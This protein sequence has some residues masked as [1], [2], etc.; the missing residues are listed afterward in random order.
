M[1]IR[2]ENVFDDIKTYDD[3][4]F[5]TI[6]T[7][8]P[9][10]LG[11][12]WVI[13]KDGSFQIKGKPVD[14]M[15][16]WGGLDGPALDEMFKEMFRVLKYGGYLLMFALDRQIGPL[17]YYAVKNGFDVNQSLYWY[18]VC[19]DETT[20]L[21]TKRGW[22]NF[23]DIK[24]DDIVLTFNKETELSEWQSIKG[25]HIYDVEDQEMVRIKN[26]NVDQLVTPNHR[27]LRK[28]K[29]NPRYEYGDWEYTQAYNLLKTKNPLS[30]LPLSFENYE[31]INGDDL[32]YELLGWIFTD[33]YYGKNDNGIRISQCKDHGVEKLETLL[34]ILNLDYSKYERYRDIKIGDYEYKNYKENIYYIKTSSLTKQ[35]KTL[36]PD[37]KPTYDLLD[38]SFE[39]RKSLLKG[40]MNG[41]GTIDEYGN[42]TFKKNEFVNNFIQSLIQ[43]LGMRTK[44]TNGVVYFCE[45]QTT[46]LQKQIKTENYSGKVWSV[47]TD[48]SNYCIRRN[49]C[50]SFTGNSNFP[51]ATDAGKMIDKRLKKDRKVVGKKKGAGSIGTTF[52]SGQ[53]YT[54]DLNKGVFQPE[55]DDTEPASNLSKIF[56]GYKYSKAP[57]KQMVE[58]IMVFSKPTKNKSV[59]DDIME[60]SEGVDL[61]NYCPKVGKKERNA[62]LDTEPDTKFT[63][64]DEGQDDRN[65]P[66]KKRPGNERN[67]H[68]T[69]KPINL[70]KEIS[71]LFKLPDIVNQKVYVPFSGSGSEVCGLISAGYDTENIYGCELN[72]EYYDIG[73]KRIKHFYDENNN[74]I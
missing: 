48:N 71:S 50:V 3:Y 2:N 54:E 63:G 42:G 33:G 30:I 19:N 51:K 23:Q 38:I 67:I 74:L 57:L 25:I 21:L 59:L 39:N 29:T 37:K 22:L 58:T 35:I 28:H 26:Q 62:G 70:I 10:N 9:Y 40:M 32:Y 5:N 36:Y 66:H 41:D 53:E 60:W 20:E 73:M 1:N 8:P 72:K 17:M 12:Q 43:T 61:L 45:R 44:M 55:Y 34:D 7:D 4:F 69:L 14:F 13:D 49:G 68:P 56:D 11:S 31:G 27:I 24:D 18:F 16:K 46:E 65:V 15:N 47:T 6:I 52:I 64:R